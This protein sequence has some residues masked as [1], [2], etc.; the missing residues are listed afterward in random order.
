M[1]IDRLW[2]AAGGCSMLI[3]CGRL[4]Q[5]GHQADSA[6]QRFSVVTNPQMHSGSPFR[7]RLIS[8]P[9]MGSLLLLLL[10]SASILF[11]P[12]S[13]A[14]L[15]NAQSQQPVTEKRRRPEF[16]PGEVLVRF[17]PGRAIEGPA[18]IAVPSDDAAVP[19]LQ[20]RDGAA[21]PMSGGEIQVN[22]D[23]F[24][25]SDLVEGLRLARMAPG[26]T[27][28]ALAA[29][30]ARSDVL[31]VEPNYIIHADV[32]PNDTRFAELYG[33]TKIGAP[34][35][36]DITTGNSSVVVGVID[37]G[38]DLSHQDLQAN[39]W[40]NPM[41]GSI[42][43]ISG[44]VNGYN[45]RDNN[46]TI[47][48]EFHATH[49][50]GTIGAVGNNNVGVVGVNW[51][52]RLMSLRFIDQTANSGTDADAIKAYNYAKQMRDLWVSSG[53]TKGA[54]IRVLNASY[55]GGGYSQAAAD[56]LNALGQSGILFVAA[57][58]N[59]GTNN[60]TDPHYPSSYLLPNVVSV[61]ATNSTDQ[62]I[63]NYGPHS[64]LLGAPGV[65]ILSTL[66]GNNYNTL[67]G[68]SMATPHVTGAAAL[69]CAANANLTVNQL[70]ALLSFNGD[71]VPSLQGKTLTGRR[72]NVFKSLQAMTEGDTTAPG[73]VSGFQVTS[74]NGRQVNLSWTASGDDGAAGQASLYDVSFVDQ[75]TSA[76]VPLT[77]VAPATSGTAQNI[78]VNIPYRH[79]SG[80]LRLRE[81]DNVGNEGT[82]AN[83]PVSVP[84]NI[85]DPYTTALN[86]AVPLSTGGTPLGL[87]FDDRYKENYQLP[88]TF[89]YFGNFNSVTI[90]TNGN[91]YFST[92]PKRP[93]GDADDV[94]G[95]ISDLSASKMIAGMWDDLDLS[96]NR[97]AGADVYVVSPDASRIIF[98]WQG[99]Q[100]GDGTNGDPI[101]FEIELRTDGSIITRYGA[102]NTNLLPVVGISGGEPDAYVIDA[103]TSEISPKTL[104]NAQSAV[105]TPRSA[106]NTLLSPSSQ[107]V[108]VAGASGTVSVTAQAGCG[109]TA[110]S[111]VPWIT[112]T[113]GSSGTGNGSVN[114]SVAANPLA[115]PRSGT[116]TIGG[117]FFTVNQDAAAP[118]VIQFN[119]PTYSMSEGNQMVSINV[120]RSGTTTNTAS[121]SF[122]T[123]DNAGSQDC[124]VTNGKA[125]ARCDYISTSGGLTFAPGETSKT[126]SILLIDD[127]YLEGDETLTVSLGNPAGA[128]LGSQPTATVTITDNDS[129][130]GPN[131]LANAGFFVRQQY[132]DFLNREPDAPG[133]AFWTDQITSCGSDQACIDDKRVNVSAAFF[134]S[135]EFQQTGYLVERIYKAAYGSTNGASTLGGTHSVLVPIIRFNE[136]LPD[137]QEIGQGVIVGQGNWQAQ[138]ESNKQAFTA[139]F[140]LRPRFT[141][142]F[143]ISLSA[144]EF[145][146]TLNSNAGNPLSTTERNLLVSD[147]N[148][149]AKTR[150]QVLRA[151]AED[152]DL[153]I[154]EFNRAFVLMQFFG[155]LR[156]NP[157]DA[158]DSDYTG[159]DFWRGKLDS[160]TVA[161]DDPLIRAQKADM[162]KAFIVAAEYRQ[163]FGP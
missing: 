20:K 17:K 7:G 125:S 47:P 21:T 108:V 71:I 3:L 10:L 30:S 143:P 162:V 26:D 98:R 42:A 6:H 22:V 161:G 124:A 39:I 73:T 35:A 75:T 133:L 59:D 69:L 58:G 102:G 156:R 41:P 18:M 149:H 87:T 101:N 140:V 96:A 103:L 15:S 131:P 84:L 111:N 121:V 65:G 24:A 139:E 83:I 119:T 144:A 49:V 32:T 115:S 11:V 77:S 106:C 52:V 141:S 104:T 61:T 99:V 154:A 150:A 5:G 93:N 142:A 163:R 56:A 44:D 64:V 105:F 128:V 120:T 62:Q 45:F 12:R 159:Y 158:P 155:Y 72:L 146:D 43:G 127:A 33:M 97:R 85:A 89:S 117:Q 138:L 114:Y 63:Y 157:N 78:T 19:A 136:F 130:T 123:S 132:L 82:P 79:L 76:V 48:P 153:S 31:Y 118:A 70:R 1:Y 134:L 107:T 88:F 147:L 112:V 109:W 68:T 90:S 116:I 160:F 13:Q 8:K 100:F 67:S 94:P 135:I 148:S 27:N 38:I 55:G 40:T 80:T 129:S 95:S 28:K 152:A 74:Q 122:A 81:F 54:N 113:A 57:A 110:I 36:W 9:F 145:V 29:I 66:P 92:P 151:V 4:L 14:I 23:R 53:G 60:D 86:S 51:Q 37:E 137:T 126:F 34:Q 16:V 91:L 46:G 25:G 2:L 50:A